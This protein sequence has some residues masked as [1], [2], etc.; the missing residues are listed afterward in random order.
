MTAAPQRSLAG[1]T[2][3]ELA[4]LMPGPH[5]GA[6]LAQLGAEVINVE[7][8]DGGDGARALWSPRPAP[9]LGEHTEEILAELNF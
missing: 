2:V 9:A 3:V 1:T 8:A 6:L 5:A 7:K 4:G